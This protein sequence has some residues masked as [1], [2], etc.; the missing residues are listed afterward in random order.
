MGKSLIPFTMWSARESEPVP[1]WRNL[2]PVV[3]RARS[4]TLLTSFQVT[5]M[6]GSEPPPEH[7]GLDRLQPYSFQSTCKSHRE[8]GGGGRWAVLGGLGLVWPLGT[9][10]SVGGCSAASLSELSTC[11]KNVSS[12]IWAWAWN[13]HLWGTGP[14]MGQESSPPP[15]AP[16]QSVRGNTA[17]LPRT[18]FWE[19]G[20]SNSVMFLLLY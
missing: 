10:H 16:V 9:L 13:A 5:L 18:F 15:M 2:G 11:L 17:Y 19:L 12:R 3:A 7:T 20:F 1:R 4:C 6:R 14:T 8:G